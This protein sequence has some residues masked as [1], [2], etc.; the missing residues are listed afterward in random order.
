MRKRKDEKKQLRIKLVK[1]SNQRN[2]K[3]KKVTTEN[4]HEKKMSENKEKN[5][6]LEEEIEEK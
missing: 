4:R 6:T 1:S 5:Y 2:Q 3:E